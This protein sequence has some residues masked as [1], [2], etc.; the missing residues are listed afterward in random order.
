VK[1]GECHV[2]TAQAKSGVD[3]RLKSLKERVGH[4]KGALD[5]V[6]EVVDNSGRGSGPK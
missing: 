1:V 4:V 2:A 5:K 6:N 3:M